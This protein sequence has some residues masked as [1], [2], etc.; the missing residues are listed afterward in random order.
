ME[1]IELMKLGQLAGTAAGMDALELQTRLTMDMPPP[2]DDTDDDGDDDDTPDVDPGPGDSDDSDDDDVDPPHYPDLHIGWR[3]FPVGHAS[4]HASDTNALYQALENIRAMDGAATIYLEPGRHYELPAKWK[5]SGSSDAPIVICTDRRNDPDHS[6]PRAIISPHIG[7]DNVVQSVG[8]DAHEHVIFD[9]VVLSQ[10]PDR[11]HKGVAFRLVGENKR[12]WMVQGCSIEGF[13]GLGIFQADTQGGI[14]DVVIHRNVVSVNGQS[15]KSQGLYAS[16]VDGLTYTENIWL[17][18]GYAQEEDRAQYAT[19][20][21]H[22]VYIQKNCTNVVSEGN[23]HWRA[24]SHAEQLRTGGRCAW[25]IAYECPLG[26][27]FGNEGEANAVIG[28]TV[29]NDCVVWR[30]ID[31]RPSNYHAGDD[32][33]EY[34]ENYNRGRGFE[35]VNGL[36]HGERLYV[37]DIATENGNSRAFQSENTKNGDRGRVQPGSKLVDCKVLTAPET[38]KTAVRIKNKLDTLHVEGLQVTD[39]IDPFRVESG[40]SVTHEGTTQFTGAHVELP[41]LHE[42]EMLGPGWVEVMRGQRRGAWNEAFTAK[43]IIALL[44][45][46]SI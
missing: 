42:D 37:L 33:Y 9:D 1:S 27:N 12:G 34:D 24:S 35:L 8:P 41:E 11:W 17:G 7:K 26:F 43:G 2:P 18:D 38:L 25:N 15:H 21:S 30:P 14:S 16:K 44:V 22:N 45:Y 28:P 6:L 10:N 46:P 40:A 29:A 23:F 36:I 19:I 31:M 5:Y 39:G 3:P 13:E 20:L 32:N 4:V